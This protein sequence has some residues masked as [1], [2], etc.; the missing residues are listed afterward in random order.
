MRGLLYA[1]TALLGMTVGTALGAP[2]AWAGGEI[3]GD[4]FRAKSPLGFREVDA[5]DEDGV[6]VRT[7]RRGLDQGELLLTLSCTQCDDERTAKMELDLGKAAEALVGMIELAGGEPQ[8]KAAQVNGA[9]EAFEVFVAGSKGSL[10]TLVARRGRQVL[11]VELRAPQGAEEEADQAWNAVLGSLTAEDPAL[12]GGVL[13]L[14][15]LGLLVL[16]TLLLRARQR[17]RRAAQA[18]A[19]ARLPQR[20]EF[21]PFESSA[22]PER[23]VPAPTAPA[24]A[25]APSATRPGCGFSR[26][27]DGLPTFTAQAKSSGSVPTDPLALPA[28]NRPPASGAVR[29][30]PARPPN[31]KP[32]PPKL[33]R[34][35]APT[36]EAGVE[37]LRAEVP[38]GPPSPPDSAPP[39]SPVQSPPASDAPPSDAEAVPRKRFTITRF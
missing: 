13:L 28:V 19:L 21:T 38:S 27:D 11:S 32:Q 18:Q 24:P 12:S 33:P 37:L 29:T 4:G 15:T 1:A 7:L 10:R 8:H 31:L 36:Q 30:A 22:P 16:I 20:S 23:Y 14:V 17:A 6:S 5:R 3:E 25:A 39:A 35:P 26:A 2:G 9:Q 34:R